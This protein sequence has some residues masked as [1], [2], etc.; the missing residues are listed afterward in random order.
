MENLMKVGF[1][2]LGNMGSAI[3]GNILKAGHQLTVW[4]RSPAPVA[5]LVGRGAMAAKTPQDALH[6]DC[7]F[8]MLANDAALREVGLAGPLLHHAAPG[9]V[10]VNLA[11]ISIELARQMAEA[12][13]ARG[14]GYVA[15]PVFGRPDAAAAAKLIVIAA[16]AGKDIARVRPLLEVVGQRVAVVGEVPEQANLFKIAGNFMLAAAIETM[17]EAIAL[18]RKGGLDPALFIQVLTTSLFAGPA[19]QGY[20]ALIVAQKYEPAGFKLQ[21][22]MKDAGLALAA[23]SQLQVP[24]PLASLVHDHFIEAMASGWAEKDWAALA[25]LAAAKAGLPGA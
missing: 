4:N 11:T 24:L 21:L 16:G 23:G 8:S 17:G 20:G 7:V 1:I 6:G 25:G 18:V 19:Y 13:A 2:G 3:A 15:A 22:G 10:H 14:V 12:H 5:E 9:L